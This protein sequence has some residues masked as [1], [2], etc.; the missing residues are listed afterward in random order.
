MCHVLL[1]SQ[2]GSVLE[3]HCV[4]CSRNSFQCFISGCLLKEEKRFSTL[5]YISSNGF[6]L[7]DGDGMEL[8]M[9]AG[10]GIFFRHIDLNTTF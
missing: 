5:I 1:V 2:Q 8:I 4:G 6:I 10:T 9:W 7:V 3:C